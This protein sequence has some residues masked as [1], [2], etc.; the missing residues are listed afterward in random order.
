[1]KLVHFTLQFSKIY[2]FQ[3]KMVL[4]VMLKNIYR[5][6]IGEKPVS[7]E[8]EEHVKNGPVSTL[9]SI[10]GHR[11]NIEEKASEIIITVEIQI[12]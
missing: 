3:F 6:I 9:I 8:V 5:V 12:V 10:I 4:I 11:G 2:E 7:L 1:M